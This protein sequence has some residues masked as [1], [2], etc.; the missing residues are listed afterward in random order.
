MAAAKDMPISSSLEDYLEAIDTIIEQNGHA[1]TKDVADMLNVTMPSVTNALQALAAR[2]LIVYRSHMPVRLTGEG[3]TK[4]AE[5]RRRHATLKRFFA[6][7]L[8]LDE[9]QADASACKIEHVIGE[10][11]LERLA[12]FTEAISERPEYAEL[13][14]FLAETMPTIRPAEDPD[15]ISLDQ[16]PK[17]KIGVVVKVAESL[18]GIKKFADLGLVPGTLVQFEGR[19]PF[20]DLIR[21]KIMGSSLSIRATDAM[22]I[23]LKIVR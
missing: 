5:I 3:A 9:P 21:I 23:W 1:H 20:G 11:A 17:D 8:K 2:G 4:A 14:K 16:L 22:Y 12:V 15:L 6:E 7:L 19:A 18:R 13:R 10:T